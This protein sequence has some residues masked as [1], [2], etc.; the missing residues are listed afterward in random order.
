MGKLNLI[1]QE[2]I[3]QNFRAE[4]FKRK[5]MKKGNLTE[6]LE[7]AMQLWINSPII[8]ALKATAMNPDITCNERQVATD[9][10]GEVGHPAIYALN[11]IANDTKLYPVEREK[12][13]KI[14]YEILKKQK[15]C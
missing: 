14:I 11:E 13:S 1:I 12:A 7:E 15:S 8:E 10:L 2:D 5:G 3:D 9:N 6:A 4:V